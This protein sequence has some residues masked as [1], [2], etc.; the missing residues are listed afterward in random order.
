MADDDEWMYQLAT[1]EKMKEA[2][3]LFDYLTESLYTSTH[4]PIPKALH[5]AANNATQ[6]SSQAPHAPTNQQTTN[7]NSALPTHVLQ[8]WQHV[9]QMLTS[10]PSDVGK[11]GALHLPSPH[12][13]LNM[14]T[15]SN[16]NGSATGPLTANNNNRWIRRYTHWQAFPWETQPYRTRKVQSEASASTPPAQQLPASS[17]STSPPPTTP[18]TLSVAIPGSCLSAA[19]LADADPPVGFGETY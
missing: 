4:T 12:K 13:N 1:M 3:K 14:S 16:S 5:M 6:S 15:N 11:E 17:S 2:Q 18:G 7:S 8:Y 9:L 19:G 10:S